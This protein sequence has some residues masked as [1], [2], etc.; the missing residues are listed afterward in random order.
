MKE[1]TW[2][3]NSL[4]Y[5]SQILNMFQPIISN[6]FSRQRNY[7]EYISNRV[8]CKKKRKNT[9]KNVSF[10]CLQFN[11]YPSL[12]EKCPNTGKYRPEITPYL[13]TFHA[14]LNYFLGI[15]K[16]QGVLSIRN[17]F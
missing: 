7:T 4:A 2:E 13:D 9:K 11:A 10:A 5:T 12:R 14:L 17:T 15:W 1:N 16:K 8:K 6:T 3:E